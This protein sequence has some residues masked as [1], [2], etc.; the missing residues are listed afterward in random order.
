MCIKM[1]RAFLSQESARLVQ[2]A[3]SDIRTRSVCS[4][5]LSIASLGLVGV[6]RHA[7]T[8]GPAVMRLRQAIVS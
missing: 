3:F 7:R 8:L 2:Y 1:H 4:V 6:P 5:D